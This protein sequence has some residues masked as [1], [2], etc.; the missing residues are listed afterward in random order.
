MEICLGTTWLQNQVTRYNQNTYENHDERSSKFS[1]FLKKYES[2]FLTEEDEWHINFN[3]LIHFINTHKKTPNKR[4]NC[5]DE[6]K[7]GDYMT[8][9][10]QNYNKKTRKMA[11][12]E[13]YDKWTQFLNKYSDILKCKTKPKNQTQIN[14]SSISE[15]EIEIEIEIDIELPPPKKKTKVKPST[16]LKSVKQEEKTEKEKGKQIK[17]TSF[18]ETNRIWNTSRTETTHKHLQEKPEEWHS[19]HEQMEDAFQKFPEEEIPRNV[20]IKKLE[21]I[22]R[23]KRITDRGCGQA[24]ISKYFKQINP[25]LEFINYDHIS[26][27]DDIIA[28]DAT[29]TELED[30]SVDIDILCLAIMGCNKEDYIKESYRILDPQGWLYVAEPTKKWSDTDTYGNIIEGTNTNAYKLKNLLVN[31]GFEI[32]D[33]DVAGKFCYFRCTKK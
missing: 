23:P 29:K 31:N 1:D 6:K 18:S 5:V 25:N 12:P 9:Q 21:S 22:K 10:N 16:P 14:Y 13:I 3:K 26:T 20:I 28:C 33:E 7:L 17:L 11:I 24:F 4:S 27:S 15:E 32:K 19:Y 8:R 2:Y 30:N